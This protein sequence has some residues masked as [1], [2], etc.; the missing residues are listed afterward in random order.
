MHFANFCVLK[1]DTKDPHFPHQKQDLIQQS[2]WKDKK[3]LS[4]CGE[5]Q[6]EK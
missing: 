6:T 2:Q 5:A 4:E 3:Q 1:N